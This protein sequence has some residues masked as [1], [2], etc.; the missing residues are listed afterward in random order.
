MTWGDLRL[1]KQLDSKVAWGSYV[2]ATLLLGQCETFSPSVLLT[3]SSQDATMVHNFHLDLGIPSFTGV[4]GEGFVRNEGGKRNSK[5]K[6]K[7]R[8]EKTKKTGRKRRH[9][10]PESESASTGSTIKVCSSF[11]PLLWTSTNAWNLTKN[12]WQRRKDQQK[13]MQVASKNQHIMY[14]S[15]SQVSPTAHFLVS[16]YP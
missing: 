13:W 16:K 2:E 6:K 10:Q 5:E 12:K 4:E 7:N 3:L 9:A 14:A 8:R 11:L 15:A 1:R